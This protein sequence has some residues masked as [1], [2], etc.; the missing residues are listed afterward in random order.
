MYPYAPGRAYTPHDASLEDYARLLHHLGFS[1]AVM[2]QPSVCGTDNRLM[3]DALARAKAGDNLG[4]Q[5]RGIAVIDDTVTDA[6]LERLNT[7]GVRGIRLNLLFAGADVGFE[8]VRRLADRIAPFGW[9]LQFLIDITAFENFGARL[10]ALPVDSVID[11]I[12]HFPAGM[13]PKTPAFVELKGLLADRK[14]WV[15][16]SGPNRISSSDHAPFSDAQALARDLLQH[17]PDRLVFGTDWPHVKL[18]GSMPD[19][20]MLVD[21]LYRWVDNDEALARKVLVGNPQMLY[22]F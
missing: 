8:Q 10:A 5:W 19:D 15:K 16:L 7:L 4:I 11:H 9:H 22:G 18:P 3:C 2:V 21:E 20:G 6:E 17:A 13:G 1:R 12:G 14:A